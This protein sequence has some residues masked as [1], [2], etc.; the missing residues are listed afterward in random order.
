MTSVV[1]SEWTLLL[2]LTEFA[3][4]QA[5][6]SSIARL[7]GSQ[8]LDKRESQMRIFRDDPTCTIMLAS[9]ACAGVG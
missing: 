2:D 3:L 8:A 6:Y 5:G 1:F 9:V 4:T 7:D